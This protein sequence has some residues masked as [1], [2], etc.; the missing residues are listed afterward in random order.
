MDINLD[1]EEV[2]NIEEL[3]NW[4]KDKMLLKDDD[5]LETIWLKSKGKGNE[6]EF[7]EWKAK[8]L[9]VL[10]DCKLTLSTNS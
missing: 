10:R 7:S 4:Y 3:I 8:F 6:L 2:K 1:S 9:S 5:Q